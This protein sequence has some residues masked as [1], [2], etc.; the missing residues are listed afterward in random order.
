LRQREE[1]CAALVRLGLDPDS[2]AELFDNLL[3]NRQTEAGA[4]VLGFAVQTFA[5]SEDSLPVL[6]FDADAVVANCEQ[7][8]VPFPLDT[9]VYFDRPVSAKFQGISDQVLK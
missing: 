8:V 3:A 9:D 2:P 1:K 6:R 5:E 4:G 7:P